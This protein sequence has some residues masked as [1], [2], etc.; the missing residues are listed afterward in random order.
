M[1][2]P[3]QT[4]P[5]APPPE[6]AFCLELGR[7]YQASGIPAH[8]FEEALTRVSQ[9]LGLEGQFFALPTAFF[10][11]LGW[12]GQQ[13]TFFQ[14]SLPGDVELERLSDLQETTDALI[15]SRLGAA[16]AAERVR[17]IQAAPPRWG[18]AMTVLCFGLG[19]APAAQFFGGGW[20]EVLLTGLFG[21]LV[22]L[23]AVL[24][25][26]R[27]GLSRLVY[28]VSGALAG[29]LALAAAWRF[30]HVSP[31]V[32]TVSGLIVLVPGLRL[33]VSMNE[34]ATGNHVSG[35]ARL[36]DTGM[37]FLSLGFGVA[38]GQRLAA[39]LLARALLGRP[40]PLPAWTLAIGLPLIAGAFVV[41]FRARPRDFPWIL[42]ASVLA[43][44][45]ARQ[46]ALW[47]GP[48]FGVGLG[49]FVL[50]LASNAFSH[51]KGRPSI[52]TLLPGLVVLVPGGLGFQGLGFIIQN[53]LV[54]GLDTAFQA[55]FVAIALLMGL[56]LAQATLQP[57][58]AL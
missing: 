55:L 31:Q 22:G 43:F 14:R 1:D 16:E 5:S 13:W 28:P 24:L 11:T 47:L 50:G 41:L 46:G 10:A 18:A 35:T 3:P 57:R 26:R 4:S 34:L 19:S 20:R 12:Q 27:Q 37:T 25:G 45:G 33:V 29:F 2:T 44:L 51:W 9:R 30:P 58:A 6:I 54:V 32:L 42:A 39:P 7:A 15:A 52:V 23:V 56:L 48:Q 21:L 8:R 17:A 49:A 53:Q 40:L 36:V 38:L